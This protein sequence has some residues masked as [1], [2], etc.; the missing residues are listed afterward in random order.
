MPAPFLFENPLGRGGKR[1]NMRAHPAV[2]GVRLGLAKHEIDML[3]A[4][5][6]AFG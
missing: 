2:L 5:G 4:V 6:C 3:H 1:V